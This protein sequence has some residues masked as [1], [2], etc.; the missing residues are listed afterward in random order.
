[1]VAM[2]ACPE[3][4]APSEEPA[5]FCL[6]CGYEFEDS[7]A[8]DPWRGRHVANRFRIE[9]RIGVGGMGDVFVAQ[10]TE[11]G[12]RVAIK[13]LRQAL[14]TDPEQVERFKREAQAASKLSHPNTIIVHDFGQD[15]DGTLFLAMEYLDGRT[16]ADVIESDGA[17]AS[18]RAVHL[19]S[20]VSGSLEEAHGQGIIHRDLKPENIFLTKRGGT[21]DFVKVLDFG[22]A[23][24]H[25]TAVGD[26]LETLT[27]AGAIF[28]TPQ[29]MSPEQI[30]GD[31]LDPR[32]DIYALGVILYQMLSGHLPFRAKTAMEMLT[33]HLSE[34]PQPIG[35]FA[36]GQ[37][38]SAHL[39]AVAL[40]ALSKKKE[41]RHGSV[42]EFMEDLMKAF[43]GAKLNLTTGGTPAIALDP[44]S[45]TD[46]RP[47]TEPIP[48][49]T[50]DGAVE[51][52]KK[53][54]MPAIL[55]LLVAA[56]IA[57]G[58][59]YYHFVHH[60]G[61][62]SAPPVAAAAAAADPGEE[63][64][65]AQ[66]EPQ[67]AGSEEKPKAEG[68]AAAPAT[69]PTKA[70]APDAGSAA[71]VAPSGEKTPTEPQVEKTP[72]Q[73]TEP[74]A[75]ADPPPSDE[76]DP[77]SGIQPPPASAAEAT[78]ATSEAEAE[79]AAKA[80]EAAAAADAKAEAPKS[81]ADAEAIAARAEAEKA[82]A[83]AEKKRFEA[84]AKALAAAEIAK[85]AA[86][87]AKEAEAA[88]AQ[89]MV[90]RAVAKEHEAQ[91]RAQAAQA[92]ADKAEALES[93]NA[94]RTARETAERAAADA[95]A[96]VE[97]LQAELAKAASEKEAAE[98]A[99]VEA[100]AKAEVAEEKAKRARKRKKPVA[101]K[102]GKLFVTSRHKGTRVYV[103]R[104]F[105]GSTPTKGIRVKSGTHRVE[106]R[107]KGK[108]E[109]KRV[110]VR[111]GKV[112]RIRF[113][114]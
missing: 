24:L 22:I 98:A 67:P 48:V 100:D 35:G 19:M 74:Q 49:E 112:Q 72:T 64:G 6:E 53:S 52:A 105:R 31:T 96:Q 61:G 87:T 70:A 66:G 38:S 95:K 58:A 111:P 47:D 10:Q 85:Q 82:A 83:E 107:Y 110:K 97:R 99:I 15:R 25:D 37:Q 11:M 102:F 40:R 2:K 77:A 76:K 109:T 45:F 114:L 93:A 68:T 21:P 14:S 33:K 34:P 84:E 101:S 59:Y 88:K 18:E 42:R 60:S 43:P 12:R 29:Y 32:S 69:S 104:K 106:A 56:T 1:M 103:D 39:E 92:E 62:G 79:K 50:S 108:K 26:K 3:C 90:E 51:A 54:S 9:K 44:H 57:G 13:L 91:A 7:A 30:R 17:I 81:A 36:K 78:T 4:N 89:A 16:L 86:A 94:A 27:R 73:P 71:A 5:R 8:E 20:Q 46:V 63:G 65:G 113:K 80:A 28:G 41:D 55:V 23:K 75:P